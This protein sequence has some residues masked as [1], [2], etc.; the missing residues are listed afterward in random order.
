MLYQYR[1]YMTDLENK[2]FS[3]D[4]QQR[5]DLAVGS[6]T[7]LQSLRAVPLLL[8]STP[9][10][11]MDNQ[12]VMYTHLLPR[13]VSD[14][15]LSRLEYSWKM[16]WG[17]LNVDTSSNIMCLHPD[18]RALFDGGHWLLAPEKRILDTYLQDPWEIIDEPCYNY[19]LIAADPEPEISN[20]MR[21]ISICLMSDVCGTT[22]TFTYPFG[23]LPP[24]ISHIHPRFVICYY[25]VLVKQVNIRHLISYSMR[26]NLCNQSITDAMINTFETWVKDIPSRSRFFRI[27]SPGPYNDIGAT[28]DNDSK[29]SL[30]TIPR[31]LHPKP[32]KRA[33]KKYQNQSIARRHRKQ[34]SHGDGL[35]DGIRL[36]RK[37]LLILEGD[38][39]PST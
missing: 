18:M 12:P 9:S 6:L 2:K 24:L 11:P 25:G 14:D 32:F 39:T 19:T 8:T 36:D 26:G 31:R 37:T 27:L 5:V 23:S 21:D 22:R 29:Q 3:E 20:P 17:T 16:P 7:Q 28:S 13:D 10:E 38:E 35:Q 30:K 4:D 34:R 1:S 33:Q 15:L